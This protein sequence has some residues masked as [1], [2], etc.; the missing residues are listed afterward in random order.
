M[1]TLIIA[2]ALFF[3]IHSFIAGT[4][5]RYWLIGKIS[6]QGY[7]AAFSVASLGSIIWMAVSYNDASIN[8]Y[9]PLWDTYP[10]GGWL[11][12]IL[13]VPALILVV[14]GLASKN[15]MSAQQGGLLEGEAP[16][17]GIMRIS[18]HPFLNGAALWAATHLIVNGDMASVIFFGT[19]LAVVMLGMGH[20]DA[21]RAREHG[22]A[23][24]AFA[25]KT[26]RLPFLA[27]VQGRN[28]LNMREIGVMRIVI[29][30]AIYGLI[31]HLHGWAFGMPV[32]L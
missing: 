5:A 6:E 14:L 25:Q 28:S 27:I 32:V 29:A 11:T 15:P 12:V 3:G 2:S 17:V 10:W 13:M 8:A 4:G 18:R 7:M 22:A 23:W 24:D 20:I 21:K 30:V 16:A 26:S 19:F 1:T 31:Y 9:H